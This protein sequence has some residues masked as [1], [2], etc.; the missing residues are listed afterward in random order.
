MVAFVRTAESRPVGSLTL[1][2]AVLKTDAGRTPAL[3]VGFPPLNGTLRL[4]DVADEFVCAAGFDEAEVGG[5]FGRDVVGAVVVAAKTGI[6]IGK[7]IVAFA[8]DLSK[9]SDECRPRVRALVTGV[10]TVR[11]R[12]PRHRRDG[13]LVAPLDRTLERRK[14]C[15]ET[16]R[17][18]T[19]LLFLRQCGGR[20]DQDQRDSDQ[21]LFHNADNLTAR[22]TKTQASAS[23]NAPT[24][25]GG[26]IRG[27]PA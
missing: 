1:P 24:Q 8:E 6:A 26:D 14:K 13:R 25:T 20:D 22:H 10:V 21:K 7:E 3:G 23:V 12:K 27:R 19:Q 17:G 11:E 4:D 9:V 16:L 15:P 18:R 2:S 5:V